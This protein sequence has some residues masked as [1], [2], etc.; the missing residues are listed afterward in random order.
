[1][2]NLCRGGFK[3]LLATEPAV[4]PPSRLRRL[5]KPLV[6][7]HDVADVLPKRVEIPAGTA[8]DG[9]TLPPRLWT[10]IGFFVLGVIVGVVV[11]LIAGATV[12]ETMVM[13]LVTGLTA[14]LM[15]ALVIG[16]NWGNGVEAAVLH[17]W[18]AGEGDNGVQWTRRDRPMSDTQRDV[19]SDEMFKRE[20]RN[21]GVGFVRR[22][23]YHRMV[24]IF[25]PIVRWMMR[26]GWI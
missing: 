25:C 6:W 24:R 12:G 16:D 26:K 4:S 15:A 11:A 7:E 20:M 5:V 18:I 3:S 19:F 9:Y 22:A 8:T 14:A 2:S 17:D 10:S 1:M 21:H 23:C 13:S